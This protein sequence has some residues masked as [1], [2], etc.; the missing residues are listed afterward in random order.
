M[1]EQTEEKVQDILL[2]LVEF[3]GNREKGFG[4]TVDVSK[5]QEDIMN[6]IQKE[7]EDA[8]K[9]IVKD[10]G[11]LK[12]KERKIDYS[13]VNIPEEWEA[14]PENIEKRGYNQAVREINNKIY[15][16]ITNNLSQTKGGEDGSK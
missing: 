12:L 14:E 6:I 7:R 10:I 4:T 13:Y 3:D 9:D 8:I 1:N 16:F 5:A 15:L 11:N 2:S